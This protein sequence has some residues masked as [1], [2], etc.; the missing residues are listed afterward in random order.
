MSAETTFHRQTDLQLTQ[1]QAEAILTVWLSRIASNVTVHC[2]GIQRLS[3]GMI[4]TVLRLDFDHNLESAQAPS[5]AVL[6]LN[7]P[8]GGTRSASPTDGGGFAAEARALIYL[9]MN[10]CFPCPQVYLDGSL[11]GSVIADLPYTFLLLETLPGINQVEAQLSPA[12]ND[13]IDRQLAEILLELHSHT[14]STFGEIDEQ[15]HNESNGCTR[16][17]DIFLPRLVE[18][19]QQPEIEQRLTNDVLSQVDQAIQQTENALSDQGQPTLIHGDIWAGNLIVH[20]VANGWRL[21]GIVDPG[22]QYADVEMELAYL[23][24]FDT[25]RTAFFETYRSQQSLHPGYE[26]R[27]L[28]YWLNTCLVHVGFFGDSYYR[29]ATARVAEAITQ[30]S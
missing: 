5:S 23:E 11:P 14:R 20:H 30:S 25:V 12:D 22:L 15:G 7:T 13:A 10:T 17:S 26:F 3:G 18:V 29:A 28:F 1:A 24:V 16:W 2:T 21:S 8:Q 6:K 4:N 19:R 9:H 27:R